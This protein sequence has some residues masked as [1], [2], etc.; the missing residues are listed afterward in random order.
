MEGEQIYFIRI[1]SYSCICMVKVFH[2]MLSIH[3]PNDNGTAHR[4]M[5]NYRKKSNLTIEFND[6][7]IYK[8]ETTVREVGVDYPKYVS[9]LIN[10]RNLDY[11]FI[12]DFVYKFTAK[13]KIKSFNVVL[14]GTPTFV[15]LCSVD[16]SENHYIFNINSNNTSED[17][18]GVILLNKPSLQRKILK[19]G[20]VVKYYEHLRIVVNKDRQFNGIT[21][22][23]GDSNVILY[24]ATKPLLDYNKLKIYYNKP[25]IE[26]NGN[27]FELNSED[28][29]AL[30]EDYAAEKKISGIDYILLYKRNDHQ[31]VKHGH[32][33]LRYIKQI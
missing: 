22:F 21:K 12:G 33:C 2:K 15:Y 9:M 5:S 31:Y 13:D 19:Y 16:N 11:L 7:H 27:T 30:M 3:M 8:S 29:V 32:P 10:I 25:K 4:G 23:N 17:S 26:Q 28:F 24:Y 14:S 6:L 20:S 18:Y 1:N